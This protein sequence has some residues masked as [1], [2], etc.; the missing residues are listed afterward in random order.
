LRTRPPNTIAVDIAMGARMHA[1]G[2]RRTRA[3]AL[4]LIRRVIVSVTTYILAELEDD[5]PSV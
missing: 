4:V 2:R 1:R 3:D 5:A